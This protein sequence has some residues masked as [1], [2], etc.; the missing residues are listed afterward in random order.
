MNEATIGVVVLFIAVIIFGGGIYL[1]ACRKASRL[2][3]K[4]SICIGCLDESES[5]CSQCSNQNTHEK[6]IASMEAVGGV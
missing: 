3:A 2:G 5:V 1:L 6:L 4:V